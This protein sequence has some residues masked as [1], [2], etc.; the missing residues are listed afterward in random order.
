MYVLK[1]TQSIRTEWIAIAAKG[2][3]EQKWICFL[4]KV[5]TFILRGETRKEAF[6]MRAVEFSNP[7]NPHRN[8]SIFNRQSPQPKPVTVV[9][10]TM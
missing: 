7:W 8:S 6:C 4:F 2:F 1:T 9:K 3:Y 10:E 5:A